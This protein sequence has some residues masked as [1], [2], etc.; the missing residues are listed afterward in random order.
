MRLLSTPYRRAL[1]VAAAAGAALIVAT[2]L[3]D[4]VAP[5]PFDRAAIASPIV[6]D[7]HQ[8]WLHAYTTPEGRWRF[9]AN[10]DEIDPLFVKRVVA[11]EDKR[12]WKHGGVDPLAVA[13]AARGALTTGRVSS[14]ASTITMQ[15]ARL[16]EPRPRTI[17]SKVAE[18]FRAAQMERRLSKREILELYLT[19][20]PYGGN[21]E[22]TRAASLIYFDK[23]PLRLT[24]AE[25]ALLIAL[26]Q[27]P[28]AR[29]PDRRAGAA[30]A[31]RDAMLGKLTRLGVITPALAAEA[32]E[33]GLRTTRSI[34]PRSAYHATLE[35]AGKAAGFPYAVVPSTLDLAMQRDVEALVS[36]AA[37]RASDGATAAAIVVDTKTREVRALA[38][39]A[40][41]GST[42]GWID[43]SRAV[44]SPG[45]T[46]KPFI[47]A[48]A[49]D[50]G[51]IGP[52]TVIEDMPQSFDGYAPE[53]FDRTFRGEITAADALQHSLNV[54]AVRV[55][56]RVGADRLAAAFT[57]AGVALATPEHANK[58]MG[59]TLALGGAGVSMR[60]LAVLYAGLAQGG[61]VKPL[62]WTTADARALAAKPAFQIVSRDTA[63]KVSAILEDSPALSGRAPAGLSENAPPVS[64]K[65]GTS[66][67]YRDA[68]AAGHAGGYAVVVWVGRADGGSRPGVTGRDAAAPVLYAVFDALWRLDPNAGR[69]VAQ[70]TEEEAVV[71]VRLDPPRRAAPP[72]IVFPRD[73]VELYADGFGADARGFSLSARGGAGAYAWYAGGAAVAKGADGRA[74]WRPE[75]PGFYDITVVDRA[76]LASKAKVRVV[77]AEQGP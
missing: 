41:V 22:G 44:R 56:D 10:L 48:L 16:L 25:Q 53:N 64:M 59:L 33:A 65:T 14:G 52:G 9:R 3:F 13:R 19:L 32:R 55:L 77:G 42:G 2:A 72:E 75:G 26:P 58:D 29:R 47:Y 49:F 28:E 57:S 68:W 71:A 35:L 18:M 37:S 76:G 12:F 54:P 23:E 27:A 11:V 43:M 21:L 67:G 34:L 20:A 50:D 24:D 6:V 36:A 8:R 69:G 63:I 30:R 4:A 40:G 31:A 45:S 74:V 7:R 61:A 39:S 60:D 46:L 70:D 66:Y 17:P 51:L 73:G 15:A 5:P 62:V 38:G 1:A